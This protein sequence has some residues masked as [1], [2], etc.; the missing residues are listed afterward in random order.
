M[1]YRRLGACGLKVSELCLGTMTFGHTTDETESEAIVNGAIDAGVTF[2]DTANTYADGASECILGKALAGR[3][4]DV[5]LATKFFNPFG[6]GP[7]D[8]G[9]SRHAIYRAVTDSLKRLGTDYIDLYYV[10]HVDTQV[11]P[12]ETLRALDDLVRG[13]LVR[14]VACSNY[15]AWRL[16]DSLW[17]SA[18]GNLE[19]YVAYQGQYNLVVRDL[20]EEVV[21][22]CLEKGVGLVAWGP[23]AGGFLTGKYQPGDRTRPGT[24]S[25]AGWVWQ[26]NSFAA[27][28]DDILRTL[29]EVAAEESR[30]ATQVALRF[31]LGRPGVASVV[32]GARTHEQFS[33]SLHASGW[34][35]SRDSYTR[36]E[37]VSRPTLRYP[38]SFEA[39]T[40]ERRDNAVRT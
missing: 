12:E 13:G 39:N 1:K 36:L 37:E 20:E 23:L 40:H 28:A 8:S 24:R 35:L 25:E 32:A 18:S 3:R 26:S 15:P 11:K 27:N 2:F 9:V 16:C 19:R 5:V 29:L 4:K 33:D 22:L 17:T 7:N 21:P 10:H 31:I 30:S 34:E 38:A 14:Y 6:P